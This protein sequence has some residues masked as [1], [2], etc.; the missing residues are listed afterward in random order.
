[1]PSYL[2]CC[3]AEI[4]VQVLNKLLTDALVAR[5]QHSPGNEGE[6]VIVK[7]DEDYDFVWK[8]PKKTAPPLDESF[9]PHVTASIAEASARYTVGSYIAVLDQHSLVDETAVLVARGPGGGVTGTVRVTF[10]SI[11][12]V[13]V[14]LENG[15]MDFSEVLSV[16]NSQGGGMYGRL[17][18]TPK[19]G[20]LFRKRNMGIDQDREAVGLQGRRRW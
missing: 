18:E 4:P 15:T 3:I 7:A 2:V 11:L 19:K 17:T 1:M 14:L 10:A 20:S 9:R 13:M 5:I 16:G 8:W 6:L 12:I